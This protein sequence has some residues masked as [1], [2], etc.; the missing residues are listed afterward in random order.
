MPRFMTLINSKL[1]SY[2]AGRRLSFFS[3]LLNPEIRLVDKIPTNAEAQ[4]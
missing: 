3:S 4:N 1:L 2:E